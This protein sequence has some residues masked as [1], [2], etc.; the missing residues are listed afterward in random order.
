MRVIW[1]WEPF[2]CVENGGLFLTPTSSSPA[3]KKI[4]LNQRVPLIVDDFLV[5]RNFLGHIFKST[6]G[7]ILKVSVRESWFLKRQASVSWKGHFWRTLF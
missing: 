7:Y 3:K 4:I 2:G 6:H 5:F 1:V